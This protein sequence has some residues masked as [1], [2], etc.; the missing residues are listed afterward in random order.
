MLTNAAHGGL[1]DLAN[2]AAHGART[3]P[4]LLGSEI[5]L[6]GLQ[7]GRA[8]TRYV[9]SLEVLLSLLMVGLVAAAWSR[10]AMMLLVAAVAAHLLV[11]S[12][13]WAAWQALPDRERMLQ[14]GT[15]HLF[16]SGLIPVL[17]AAA[18]VSTPTAVA[19]VSA[20]VLPPAL[21]MVLER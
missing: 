13:G 12:L 1:R 3:T 2:D 17:A 21:T 6:D 10:G 20:Y 11:L 19:L 4:R 7:P 5:T 18:L 14:L 8:M 16:G 15:V 9:V